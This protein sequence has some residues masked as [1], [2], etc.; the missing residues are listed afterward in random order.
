MRDFGSTVMQDVG[1]PKGASWENSWQM[2]GKTRYS[3]P[4]GF[5]LP[6]VFTV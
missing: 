5:L 1:T 6:Y 4:V 2:R 3:S